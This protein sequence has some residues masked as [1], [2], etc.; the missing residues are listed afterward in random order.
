MKYLK[1]VFSLFLAVGILFT[2]SATINLPNQPNLNAASIS[3]PPPA[4]VNQVFPDEAL[5]EVVASALGKVPTDQI[6]QAELNMIVNFV[7]YEEPIRNISG[8]EYMT[9]LRTLD[10]SRNSITD[11]SSLASANFTQLQT[12]NLE[13]QYI[14]Y[15]SRPWVNTIQLTNDITNIDDSLLAP[16]AISNSG[17]YIPPTVTWNMANPLPELTYTFTTPVTVGTINGTYSGTIAQPLEMQYHLTFINDGQV[18]EQRD[19]YEDDIIIIPTEPEKSG[20][21]FMGWN[22]KED[23]SGDMWNFTNDAMP[24]EDLTLYAQWIAEKVIYVPGDCDNNDNNAGTDIDINKNGTGKNVSGRL[25]QTGNGVT[26]FLLGSIL[27]VFG[28]S[29]LFMAKKKIK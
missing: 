27:L 5:A 4:A 12:L 23:G 14:E 3:T 7:V 11:I 1:T 24:A 22:T 8:V 9:R 25:P 20:Y 18:Y 29:A 10:M 6:T 16:N 26:E 2:A 19:L 17:S 13:D 15:P 28:T 21:F